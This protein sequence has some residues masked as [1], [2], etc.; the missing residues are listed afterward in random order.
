MSYGYEELRQIFIAFTDSIGSFW[1]ISGLKFFCISFIVINW[2]RR[3]MDSIGSGL[4]SKSNYPVLMKNSII[5]VGLVA[6]YDF[7][8]DGLDYMLGG[9]ETTYTTYEIHSIIQVDDSTKITDETDTGWTD[10]ITD[11][12]QT[13]V[14]VFTDPTFI[15]LKILEGFAW[16][17]DIMIYAIY[18][19]E[20]FFI[21]F[22]L[23]AIG[24]IALCVYPIEEFRTWTWKW[25]AIYIVVFLTII[26]YVLIN[27]LG[28]YV[29]TE[30]QEYLADV[31]G[32]ASNWGFGFN[33][34]MLPIILISI[35]VKWK[36]FKKSG[37]IVKDVFG[38]LKEGDNSDEKQPIK[39]NG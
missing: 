22:I 4:N 7:I 18:M 16:L 11:M 26:P 20:R 37:E 9:I 1:I 23:K 15:L 10:T 38:S 3:Y 13:T 25:L 32:G 34:F 6:G 27:K 31:T 12:A 35:L 30:S 2:Y 14:S 39:S 21:L 29:F 36:V 24:S 8:L 17:L 33:S 5:A 19:L 28:N